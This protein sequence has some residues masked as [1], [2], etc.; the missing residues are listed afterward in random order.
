[1]RSFLSSGDFVGLAKAVCD[2]LNGHVKRLKKAKAGRKR[3]LEKFTLEEQAESYE[4]V[5]LRSVQKRRWRD[6]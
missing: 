5:F 6:S 3:V 1:M 4:D 2:E